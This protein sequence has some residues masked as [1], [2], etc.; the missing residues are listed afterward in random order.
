MTRKGKDAI[1]VQ[2]MATEEGNTAQSIFK[3]HL[4]PDLIKNQ[5]TFICMA[6]FVPHFEY[7]ALLIGL[8]H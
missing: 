3:Q 7:L 6:S 1:W 2:C 8:L 5:I 4:H